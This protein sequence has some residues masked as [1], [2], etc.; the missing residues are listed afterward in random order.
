MSVS[1]GSFSAGRVFRGGS[2][3]AVPS[4]YYMYYM[5]MQQ[6]D[7]DS[8]D[9]QVT[10]RSGRGAHATLGN[11]T[12]AEA[13]ANAGYLTSLDDDAHSAQLPI[14][15]WTHRMATRSLILSMQM[16]ATKGASSLRFWGSG[17]GTGSTGPLLLCTSA[18]AIQF[19]LN[20]TTTG[21]LQTFTGT[22]ATPYGSSGLHTVGIAY[23]R[24]T[25]TVHYYIDG[26]FSSA[27]SNLSADVIAAADGAYPAYISLS[28]RPAGASARLANTMRHQH[29]LNVPALPTNIAAVMHRLHA[30]PRMMLSDVDL[31][32]I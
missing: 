28:G 25:L 1:G 4:S 29:A 11:L 24:A 2:Q 19:G 12:T 20:I 13:W 32:G 6:A 23:D 14:A 22:A 27:A 8:D 18:G 10:D 15:H 30:H 5:P 9:D 21:T 16:S 17:V 31:V 26:A 3:S 7:G